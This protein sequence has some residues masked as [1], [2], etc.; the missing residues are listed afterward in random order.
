MRRFGILLL[1]SGFLAS[2]AHAW[3]QRAMEPEAARL[4]GQWRDLNSA[5]RGGSGDDPRTR[6]A[7][8]R[9]DRL[10]V[11]LKRMGWCYGLPNDIG[12]DRFWRRCDGSWR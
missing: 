11:R 10:T 9:R 1:A 6:A 4:T 3:Q 5:C 7:C 12:A 8:S 2:A